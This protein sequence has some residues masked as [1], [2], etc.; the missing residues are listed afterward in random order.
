MR[1]HDYGLLGANEVSIHAPARGATSE[2]AIKVGEPSVSIH[3]PARGATQGIAR[4]TRA[5]GFQSTHPHGVRHG[6]VRCFRPRR[7]VSIH[8]PARG[9][10]SALGRR[11][12]Q[13]KFQS[14]HPHGV[15]PVRAGLQKVP[16]S[17]NPRTR[18][19]C[20]FTTFDEYYRYN[21]SIHAPA[22]GATDVGKPISERRPFQS[23]HPHGVRRFASDYYQ[24]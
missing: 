5:K 3:A 12:A 9:A 14:T 17:F 4:A 22:R 2:P 18:T 19:G 15:R 23:T 10:T 1:R 7:K 13:S 20:D 6:R 16:Q 11:G 8:A 21:V 24:V